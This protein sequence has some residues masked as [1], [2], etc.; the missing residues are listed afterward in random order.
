MGKIVVLVGPSASGKTTIQNELAFPKIVTTTTRPKR[1]GERSGIDYH[2]M[3][4][5]KFKLAI[6]NEEFVEYV[7]YAGNF[8]G[9]LKQ[10]I[11]AA[12]NSDGYHSI[13]LDIQG[14]MKLKGI[15]PN[16]VIVIVITA[17]KDVIEKR[18]IERNELPEVIERRLARME[19]DKK[20]YYLA[21]HTFSNDLIIDTV[22]NIK[23]ILHT[24]H[25]LST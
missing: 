5:E 9:S 3:T 22:S 15:F 6:I 14:A 10:T 23:N 12:I 13:V 19:E 1:E 8:Y 24:F 18:L 2:F 20:L 16:E 25:P 4:K 17:P 21:E 7:E 11:E